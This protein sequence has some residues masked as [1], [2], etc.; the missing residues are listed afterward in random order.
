MRKILLFQSIFLR[1][2]RSLPAKFF[3]FLA[4]T[5]LL[6]SFCICVS[7]SPLASAYPQMNPSASDSKI[8]VAENPT[9]NNA[10]NI[11]LPEIRRIFFPE[12]DVAVIPR[13]GRSLYV[14]ISAELFR[15]QMNVLRQFNSDNRNIKNQN[16]LK[17]L[18]LHARL[19]ENRILSGKG[20]LQINA[21]NSTETVGAVPYQINLSPFQLAITNP[22]WEN[23]NAQDNNN[24]VS[25]NT[26]QTNAAQLGL[27]PY[28]EITLNVPNNAKTLHFDWT[29]QEQNGLRNDILFL[30]TLPR[31][32]D[33]RLT[34]DLPADKKPVVPSGIVQ[35]YQDEKQKSV[36]G[37]WQDLPQNYRR[38]LIFF[39]IN[40][41]FQAIIT[42]DENNPKY[43]RQIGVSSRQSYDLS[44]YGMQLN[45]LFFLER[46]FHRL[47][48]LTLELDKPLY[49]LSV[50]LGDR[51]LSWSE[52]P[53]DNAAITRL[54]VSI[55]QTET[56][57]RE[58]QIQ[59]F[60]PVSAG[61]L[62][63]LPK[64]RLVSPLFFWSETRN[65]VRVNHPLLTRRIDAPEQ[66]QDVPASNAAD[67]PESDLFVFQAFSENAKTSVELGVNS[68]SLFV[69]SGASFI[70]GEREI[71]ARAV[72]DVAV[73]TGRVQQLELDVAANWTVDM[74]SSDTTQIMNYDMEDVADDSPKRTPPRST[75]WVV[76]F[77][78]MIEPSQPIR[79]IVQLRRPVTTLQNAV[80]A[81]EKLFE[82]REEFTAQIDPRRKSYHFQED[83]VPFHV[84]DAREGTRLVAFDTSR[85]Y[86]WIS[87]DAG[88]FQLPVIPRDRVND[89]FD[90]LPLGTVFAVDKSATNVFLET[91]PLQP[92]YEM[93]A[94]TNLSLRNGYLVETCRFYCVPTDNSRV[95]RLYVNFS[96]GNK[97]KTTTNSST[98]DNDLLSTPTSSWNWELEQATETP[99][100]K[101]VLTDNPPF[102]SWIPD[103]ECWEITLTPS[104]SLPF[105]MTAT[106]IF[107]FEK[108]MKIP[109]P[110]FPEIA[111]GEA[112][113][114]IETKDA[115]LYRILE[116]HAENISGLP[117]LPKNEN[118]SA[119]FA[120]DFSERLFAVSSEEDCFLR[121]TYRYHPV[122]SDSGRHG[123]LILEPQNESVPVSQNAAAQEREN[124]N[125]DG[126]LSKGTIW[127]MTLHTRY[128]ENGEHVSYAVIELE[129][130]L[131]RQLKIT[132]PRKI[133]RENIRNIWVDHEK[134]IWQ[135]VVNQSG[136]TD[137][138]IDLSPQQRY[139]TIVI[140]YS[141]QKENST[142]DNILFPDQFAIEVPVIS[143]KWFAWYPPQYYG[144]LQPLDSPKLTSGKFFNI[145]N[146]ASQSRGFSR[147]D[148]PIISDPPLKFSL[149]MSK[150]FV[151]SCFSGSAQKRLAECADRLIRLFNDAEQLRQIRADITADSTKTNADTKSSATTN[152][153]A[154]NHSSPQTISF[155]AD[156]PTWGELLTSS[157]FEN[158][159]SGNFAGRPLNR[160]IHPMNIFVDKNSLAYFNI[161]ADSPI[162]RENRND[163]PNRNLLEKNHLAVIFD[164]NDNLLVTT[165]LLSAKIRHCLMPIRPNCFWY[166]PHGN[167]ATFLQKQQ[168]TNNFFLVS[169][170]HW[171]SNADPL[172]F[173]SPF[174]PPLTP[175]DIY[176][177]GWAARELENNAGSRPAI[178]LIRKSTLTAYQLLAFFIVVLTA[179]KIPLKQI[180]W[181]IILLILSV[182]AIMFFP[183]PY[184]GIAHGVF[185]G[186]LCAV[187][188]LL[189]RNRKLFVVS[190]KPAGYDN[191]TILST[192][193]ST[194]DSEIGEVRNLVSQESQQEIVREPESTEID[195]SEEKAI[196]EEIPT[197][198]SD[199]K[200]NRR[201]KKEKSDAL[202][203]LAFFLVLLLEHL[204]TSEVFS[205]IQSTT[206]TD[207]FLGS[208][209]PSSGIFTEQ[210]NAGKTLETAAPQT[211][212]A[213][214]LSNH[215]KNSSDAAQRKEP[216][217]VFIPYNK[218]GK[219]GDLY[220][221]PEELYRLLMIPG[222]NL[223]NSGQWQIQ[224]ANYAGALVRDPIQNEIIL[225]NLKATY[226]I[227]LADHFASVRL[228]A[229][230]ILPDGAKCDRRLIQPVF[231]SA[232]NEYLFTI[233]GQ[234]RHQLEL[235]LAPTVYDEMSSRQFEF[236]IPGIPDSTL[237]LTY[238]NTASPVEVRY[239]LGKISAFSNSLKAELGAVNKLSV[240]WITKPISSVNERLNASQYFLLEIFP[241]QSRL[242]AQYRFHIAA[243]SPTSQVQIAVDP[244]YQ[245]DG[246]YRVIGG[247][248]Q[249]DS[250]TIHDNV[251]A[252]HFRHPVTENITLQANYI[253]KNIAGG[254]FSGLGIVA[255]PRFSVN[256]ARL[257]RSWLGVSPGAAQ[258]EPPLS[259]IETKIFEN[260]W[261]SFA[262]TNETLKKPV[263]SHAYDLLRLQENWFLSIKSRPTSY[264]AEQRQ[265]VFY[266]NKTIHTVAEAEI[267]P[268]YHNNNAAA[269]NSN[270]S[271][272]AISATLKSPVSDAGIG[273]TTN[274]ETPDVDIPTFFYAFQTPKNFR[275]ESVD[276]KN[277]DGGAAEKPRVEQQ[278]EKLVLFFQKAVANNFTVSL[279][280]IIPLEQ[281]REIP[282]PLITHEDQVKAN[283][284][285]YSYRDTSV[286]VESKIAET[287]A[288]PVEN[289]VNQIPAG[290]ADGIFLSA[291]RITS[292]SDFAASR[293]LLKPN[294]PRVTG[295]MISQLSRNVNSDH[296]DMSVD[297]SLDISQGELDQIMIFVPVN[298]NETLAEAIPKSDFSITQTKRN[299]GALIQVKPH[300]PLA[301]KKTF[302]LQFPV[303]GGLDSFTVPN[304][305]FQTS[306]NI[307]K[308]LALLRQFVGKILDW[309]PANLTPIV[310]SDELFFQIG[311][312]DEAS[313]IL[314]R[315]P[316]QYQYYR[317]EGD[318]FSA[319]LNTMEQPSFV[320]CQDVAF[321]V[322][323]N[324]VCF[325][326][327][328]FDI[329]N[330]GLTYCDVRIPANYQ[331]VQVQ[332]NDHSPMPMPR[333]GHVYRVELPTDSQKQRLTIV[334]CSGNPA[335]KEKTSDIVLP[336]PELVDLPVQKTI[337]ECYYED[338]ADPFF[339]SAYKF[340]AASR[341]KINVTL[342]A[343]EKI[344]STDSAKKTKTSLDLFQKELTSLQ[345]SN[346]TEL[347][348]RVQLFR[349]NQLLT[350]LKNTPQTSGHEE[351]L[352]R[353]RLWYNQWQETDEQIKRSL[354]FAASDAENN[355]WLSAFLRTSPAKTKTNDELETE[356][357]EL[358]IAASFVNDCFS[359]KNT[360]QLRNEAVR[361]YNAI[362]GTSSRDDENIPIASP[363]GDNR[364]SYALQFMESASPIHYIAGLGTHS[365]AELILTRQQPQESIFQNK[366]SIA[367][368]WG[369]FCI[370]PA[371]LLLYRRTAPMFRRFSV[372]F[373][374]GLVVF[375]W[376]FARPNL[377]GWGILL[378]LLIAVLRVQWNKMRFATTRLSQKEK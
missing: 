228:P 342:R 343:A 289:T 227:E 169:A 222:R 167:I 270:T 41:P 200:T 142:N 52:I 23:D 104:R 272:P 347:W 60:C 297:C 182:T 338:T 213:S 300:K 126:G 265:W 64:A 24:I 107:P 180:T 202:T 298:L 178:L 239:A 67:I 69:Q 146:G 88:A 329:Q 312:E 62:W 345:L 209:N 125:G 43:Y 136:K 190:P 143:Q 277:A 269:N 211:S 337:W 179:W 92:A 140:E 85:K 127:N 288:R 218:E 100:I 349:Q 10:D 117:I 40:K 123:L 134:G 285:V 20:I 96:P 264:R 274:P 317:I 325:A 375:C 322:R 78:K 121:E 98:A 370:V 301:G 81:I 171:K 323:K 195:F 271:Y 378:I 219:T 118:S 258:I 164:A 73:E 175:P 369:A 193:L 335:F 242:Y 226:E 165:S 129:N 220:Y 255:L 244:R 84:V 76:Q 51:I 360:A 19:G 66:R 120:D 55:P 116:N 229:T 293:I 157:V 355:A 70:W 22:V 210:A 306:G 172:R 48:Y 6:V 324:N 155:S 105:E 232:D 29:L 156:I 147:N 304:V 250:I 330:Y 236:T 161:Y 89:R 68:S 351:N 251:A 340:A 257:D 99:Q 110:F 39:N 149:F 243:S 49:P 30:F 333:G 56:N 336:F 216:Y 168:E 295:K 21:K 47:E 77:R 3:C 247:T 363:T 189:L 377:I 352:N 177:D 214:V 27:D 109:T 34:L 152:P 296:W 13:D 353:Y 131:L 124:D 203:F 59:S 287:S 151:R 320:S 362:S 112:L 9:R 261:E 65:I 86:R 310:P 101:A 234:G 315:N 291:F 36:N 208:N 224:K 170:N 28:G 26:E 94:I 230:P 313:H 158:Q 303:N 16:V 54:L 201:E 42:A 181:L 292:L 307:E 278:G 139:T 280:G 223:K 373:I 267:S 33:I 2:V 79:F 240:S 241:K 249:I 102:S 365:I 15:Q 166:F 361:Q 72:V 235:S 71:L 326:V 160:S 162:C 206:S 91:E 82:N 238:P 217:S 262:D 128:D 83:F 281:D 233:V 130:R 268:S 254:D 371:F 145:F 339:S 25:E 141:R 357:Q 283:Y 188:F 38:W 344:N 61:Q 11:F 106:R 259:N 97:T 245:Q 184:I 286:L 334:A 263:V 173:K 273:L 314:T 221:I 176:R 14:N 279:S 252:I 18:R 17:S 374:I 376:F 246:D 367:F 212:N 163:F 253:L 321:F 191:T 372:F 204:G 31:S 284:S 122:V 359:S 237:E 331:L 95:E 290:F 328:A 108:Q 364:D 53:S 37:E 46:S 205:Q 231:N 215:S 138:L 311:N 75:R 260:T 148:F 111:T 114:H 309:T 199:R 207:A 256:N 135:S 144:Y 197:D 153:P 248:A 198:K 308:Y 196:S 194:E 1:N 90:K 282:F 225:F 318:E 113:F 57:V 299:N 50:K 8:P 87:P 80:P 276:V 183:L 185:W 154:E 354:K 7:F 346:R 305:R 341:N 348:T 44:I 12:D 137:I 4:E 150:Q 63:E 119:F 115:I 159:V 132:T 316:E 174:L 366:Y 294:K 186:D 302:R 58:L 356:L 74:I 45:A 192:K 358:N 350:L 319:S 32:P 35:L 266:R 103:G 275:Y 187:A 332:L 133:T 368:F 93:S 5:I 327:S